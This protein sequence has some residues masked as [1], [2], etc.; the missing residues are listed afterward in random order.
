VADVE[1][2]E[3]P[4]AMHDLPPL[5]A[6]AGKGGGEVGEGLDLVAGRHA[7][8]EVL[9]SSVTRRSPALYPSDHFH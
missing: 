4:V 3:D 8:R 1:E 2:V 5:A 6:E 7:A 9:S